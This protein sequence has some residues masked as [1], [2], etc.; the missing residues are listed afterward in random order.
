MQ[1][2]GLNTSDN[3]LLARLERSEQR[4]LGRLAEP[5][6]LA[7]GSVLHEPGDASASVY[8]PTSGFVSLLAGSAT[9]PWLEVGMVGV[10]GMVGSNVVL[11][12]DAIPL[13][14]VVQGQGSALR[15]PRAAF[16]THLAGSASLDRLLRLYLH[17]VMLQ[18]VS[19]APCVRFHAITPRLA[20]WLLMSQDR[21]CSDRFRSTHQ[22][23]AWMLGVRRAGVSVAA[24]ELQAAG[25][26]D[27]VR[28][29][30]DVLDRP[31]LEAMACSCYA[32]DRAAYRDGM[33]ES[34]DDRDRG[35]G[36][37]PTGG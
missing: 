11:G 1:A 25:L 18:Y 29:T 13:R 16:R 3:L 37:A 30:V 36:A 27:Y 10:E 32:R 19:A 21:A 26:I 23:L 34:I 8:F 15:I 22:F 31:G 20:R 7:F 12:V 9:L 4:S 2:A 5:A 14:V 6:D 17:V 28:G 24:A 33:G 35:S